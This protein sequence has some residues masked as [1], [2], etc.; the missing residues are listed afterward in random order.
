[1]HVQLQAVHR[2]LVLSK[3]G[4]HTNT[5]YVRGSV[6]GAF[7]FIVVPNAGHLVPHDQPALALALIEE[8]VGV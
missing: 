7:S 5:V 6:S 4:P 1:M 3:A 2:P 8:F